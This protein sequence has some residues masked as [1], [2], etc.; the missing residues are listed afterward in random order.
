[1]LE[2]I[3][4]ICNFTAW[5]IY[6]IL[7]IIVVITFIGFINVQFFTKNNLEFS[8][9][10]EDEY[11]STFQTY[12]RTTHDSKHIIANTS[13]RSLRNKKW[14]RSNRKHNK[15]TTGIVKQWTL[16]KRMK[17]I[18]AE[19][20]REQSPSYHSNCSSSVSST[21]SI[22]SIS[23]VSISQIHQK[24][25]N[26]PPQSQSQKNYTL[27][28]NSQSEND[29]FDSLDTATSQIK[30]ILE[31]NIDT[32]QCFD[33]LYDFM[34]KF[35][36]N[37]IHISQCIKLQIQNCIENRSLKLMSFEKTLLNEKLIEISTKN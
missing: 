20:N 22:H 3:Y 18:T 26:S 35:V 9:M 30:N 13:S 16:S 12:K 14:N 24:Y 33:D 23:N 1:M 28:D 10:L 29:V 34:T 31:F 17:T 11:K 21:R 15:L 25:T 7:I 37:N 5:L 27:S 19:R 8:R 32:M 4:F 2:Q 36:T 6:W